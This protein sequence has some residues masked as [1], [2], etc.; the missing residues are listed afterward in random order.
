MTESTRNGMSGP[1]TSRMSKAPKDAI[2]DV[3]AGCVS[4]AKEQGACIARNAILAAGLPDDL[5]GVTVNRF[6]GSGLQAINFGAMG[7]LSGHQGLVLAGGVESMSRVPM[8]SDEAGIDGHNLHLR[9][10]V[11]QVPQG[12]SADLIATIEGFT[13]ADVDAFALESQRR[14]E[15]AQKE[16]RFARSIFGVTD[17]E[18]GK[19]LLEVDEH[20]RH[21]TTI[22]ALTKLDPAF[23]Q[24]G[25]MPVGPA[26]ETFDE[27]ARRRYPDVAA[28]T[29]VHT[30]GNSSGIVDGACAVLLASDAA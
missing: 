10:K 29:H 30:A 20:A 21:G 2:D 17:P 28:I 3:I 7:V 1:T 15:V 24:M 13:R 25:A 4:Q 6:C 19:V 11:F 22:E 23:G 9:R 27:L 8:G 26:G 14:A 12:I 5:T 18:T 16:N